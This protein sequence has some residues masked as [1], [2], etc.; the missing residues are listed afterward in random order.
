MSVATIQPLFE[1]LR[2]QLVPMVQAI[3]GQ[4][5]ID[6]SCLHRHY[7]A[8]EQMAFGEHVIRRLGYDFNRGRQDLTHHP[9][10]I[11]F[12]LGD[13]RITTRVDENRLEEGLF[14]TIH[15]CGHALYEQGID[16]AYDATPLASGTSSTVHESQ[17]RLWENIVGRSRGFWRHFYPNSR[18]PSRRSWVASPWT[19]STG[20]STRCSGP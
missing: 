12:S 20:R 7:P 11:T 3:G 6:D 18:P 14:S 5:P 4:E 16:M 8:K 15:E 17:S 10:M 19:T 9:F 13:V 2:Q 1:E